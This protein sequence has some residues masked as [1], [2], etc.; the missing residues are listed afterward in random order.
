MSFVC[1]YVGYMC[2]HA[3]GDHRT[4]LENVPQV[5]IQCFCL[6]LRHI[7]TV[8]EFA[9]YKIKPHFPLVLF[10]QFYHYN[11][12]KPH[13]SLL[14]FVLFFFVITWVLKMKLRSSGLQGKHFPS[15]LIFSAFNI[16]FSIKSLHVII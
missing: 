5:P 1:V 6:F 3:F 12:L 8:S 16:A 10:P 4:T 11:C 15:S 13:L 2:L 14:C 7:L 9:N